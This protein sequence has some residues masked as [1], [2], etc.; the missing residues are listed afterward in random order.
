MIFAYAFCSHRQFVHCEGLHMP[1]LPLRMIWTFGTQSSHPFYFISVIYFGHIKC[2]H[3]LYV[4]QCVSNIRFVTQLNRFACKWLEYIID[5]HIYYGASTIELPSLNHLNIWK[6]FSWKDW[7]LTS[8]F[9]VKTENENEN[10]RCPEMDYVND[11]KRTHGA[12]LKKKKNQQK[13]YW[14]IQLKVFDFPCE[15]FEWTCN[16]NVK[17]LHLNNSSW[18]RLTAWQLATVNRQHCHFRREKI[19]VPMEINCE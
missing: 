16:K 9:R 3:N 1:K 14:C 15:E 12:Q 13:F 11:T 8:I 17:I 6:D 2:M 5:G 19:P 10:I 7:K 18:C 4:C